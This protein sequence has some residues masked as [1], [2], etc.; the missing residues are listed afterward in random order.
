MAFVTRETARFI[1]E[2][3]KPG[4]THWNTLYEPADRVP[5]SGIYRCEGCGDE[6]TSNAGDPFPPQNRHQHQNRS[7]IL[8]RLIVRTRTS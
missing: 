6:I 5:V 1:T 2:T 7:A 3:D 4:N 8:W